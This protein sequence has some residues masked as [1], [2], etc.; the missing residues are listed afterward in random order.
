MFRDFST[1]KNLEIFQLLFNPDNF[2]AQ[3]WPHRSFWTSGYRSGMHYNKF[4]WCSNTTSSK[5]SLN[6]QWNSGTLF[7]WFFHIW[8]Q[9]LPKIISSLKTQ[10]LKIG[11][12]WNTIKVW[13][14]KIKWFCYLR[15]AFKKRFL[16][17]VS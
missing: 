5:I 8:K 3:I 2:P 7:C 11:T 12:Y 17:M 14:H 4:M 10:F 9:S 15:G 1:V 13:N 6:S 16:G